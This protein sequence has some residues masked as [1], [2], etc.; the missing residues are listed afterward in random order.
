MRFLDG[1]PIIPLA[2]VR[3]RNALHLPRAVCNYTP[4]GRTLIHKPLGVNVA[5]VRELMEEEISGESIEYMDNRI[6]LYAAQHGKCAVLGIPLE[7]EE[8]YCHRKIP[9]RI[10]GDDRYANLII[11][12]KDLK[13]ALTEK[14]TEKAKRTLSQITMDKQKMKK[15]NKIR[16][17]ANLN[18][19]E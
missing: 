2:Y 9:K 18:P 4:E 8:I 19:I 5:I 1:Y 15:L 12:H 10:G 14:D 17:S 13:L 7:K 6:S 11:V 16:K 3:T